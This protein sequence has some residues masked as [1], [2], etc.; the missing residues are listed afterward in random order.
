MAEPFGGSLIA[1]VAS[2]IFPNPAAKDD[3]EERA[4]RSLPSASNINCTTPS[5]ANIKDTQDD[6]RPGS[7]E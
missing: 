1:E 5:I 3:V 2:L 6:F 4:S 7:D